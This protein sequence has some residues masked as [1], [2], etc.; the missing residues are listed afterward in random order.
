MILVQHFAVNDGIVFAITVVVLTRLK[1][2]CCGSSASSMPI[3]L[4]NSDR[5]P[6]SILSRI[7]SKGFAVTSSLCNSRLRG[8]GTPTWSRRGCTDHHRQHLHRTNVPDTPMSEMISPWVEDA[9]F[10]AKR[11]R[12]L[13]SDSELGAAPGKRT[14]KAPPGLSPPVEPK[15]KVAR[16]ELPRPHMWA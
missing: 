5:E 4:R 1:S 8:R 3:L 14:N 7:A 2:V 6:E 16:G 9:M 12:I 13:D 15:V 11:R 10:D